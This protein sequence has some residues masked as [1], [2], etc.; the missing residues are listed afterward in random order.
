MVTP[1]KQ[2]GAKVEQARVSKGLGKRAAARYAGVSESRWRQVETGEQYR[3]G[4]KIPTRTSPDILVKMARAME[5]DAGEI[6]ELYG[7]DPEAAEYVPDNR[8]DQMPV[9]A[10]AP[11]QPPSKT[12]DISDLSPKEEQLL[13]VFL[14]TLSSPDTKKNSD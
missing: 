8:A 10:D 1:Q 12:I 4:K 2:V 6:L 11:S 14:L 9:N 13:R 7:F 3:D 5:L